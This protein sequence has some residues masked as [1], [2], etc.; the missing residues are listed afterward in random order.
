MALLYFIW[1]QLVF[2]LKLFNIYTHEKS[3]FDINL[4]LID[5]SS[6]IGSGY[7]LYQKSLRI[8]GPASSSSS[9]AIYCE[10]DL[11][12]LCDAC[13]SYAK[14]LQVPG[15]GNDAAGTVSC[16]TSWLPLCTSIQS[17]AHATTVATIWHWAGQIAAK[18]MCRN[19]EGQIFFAFVRV[20]EASNTLSRVVACRNKC[21]KPSCLLLVRYLGVPAH[22]SQSKIFLFSLY[23]L[24]LW[25]NL[26]LCTVQYSYI[27][28]VTRYI[29]YCR[30]AFQYAPNVNFYR[31]WKKLVYPFC[32]G[33][34]F[35]FLC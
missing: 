10:L 19:S 26:I 13:C 33:A 2:P 7:L 34:V 17:W 20:K 23:N 32:P 25:I 21:R 31:T 11:A 28:N 14:K 35:L 29:V 12:R 22:C 16:G 6:H 3:I 15:G 27:C 24:L 4:K 1:Y 18:I 9:P 8:K 5:G 30:A